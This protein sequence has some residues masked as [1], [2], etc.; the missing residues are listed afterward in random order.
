MPSKFNLTV[1]KLRRVI[2]MKNSSSSTFEAIKAILAIFIIVNAMHGSIMFF[3]HETAYIKEV[4]IKTGFSVFTA[5]SILLII[6]VLEMLERKRW[7]RKSD[8]LFLNGENFKLLKCSGGY[9]QLPIITVFI[10]IMVTVM[11]LQEF[12][13]DTAAI[14]EL[15]A[16]ETLL[17]PFI[18]ICFFNIYALFTVFYYC[19]Y[20]VCYTEYSIYMVHFLRKVN[21]SC[22]DIKG[23]SFHTTKHD[24]DKIVIV[25]EYNRLVLRSD[26]LSDGWDEFKNYIFHISQSRNII[27][28]HIYK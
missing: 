23:I 16:D 3:L 8:E 13:T 28:E 11:L 12:G 25:T 17:T 9:Y 5:I 19:C 24:R 22:D 1:I 6:A 7:R 26:V 14:A 27:V 21:I 20:K 10:N 2:K 18:T 15:I 4:L